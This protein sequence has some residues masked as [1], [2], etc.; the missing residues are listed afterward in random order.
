[1]KKMICLR[2]TL[3]MMTSL[4]IPVFANAETPPETQQGWTFSQR[5]QG[6][7]NAAGVVLKTSST[8]TYAFNRYIKVYAGI[9][10]Y[11][12]RATS[13][14]GSTQFLNGIGNVYSGLLVTAGGPGF[15]YTSDLVAT[16][17]TGDTSRGFSTGHPTIDW[18]NTFSHGFAA[19]TPYVSIGA[20]NTV[21]DTSF[22]VRPF[23]S[24]GIV[25][26]YEAGTVF[27][28][29]SHVSVGGSVYGVRAAGEQEIIS[30]V[31][32]Q[33][34]AQVTA[35]SAQQSPQGGP[36]SNVTKIAGLGNALTG[37]GQV[38][39]TAVFE[40]QQQTLGP[41]A[42]ANDHGFSTWLSVR[43]HRSTDFQ[44][45]YSRSQTYQLNSLFFGVGFRFGR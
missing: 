18:T 13:S 23:S 15:R 30:K 21:S 25:G 1:M 43:P 5:F 29:T 27:A 17:P 37:A 35:A 36:L 22:F 38:P 41:A 10:V 11:F 3:V 40:T 33:P 6:S 16:A 2:R 7:S 4:L 14:T 26:H 34:V 8:G 12:A 39:A 20:A 31:V 28:I 19:F 45:G 9:P 24:K 44:V 42:V 32:E